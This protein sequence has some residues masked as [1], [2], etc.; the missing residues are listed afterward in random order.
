MVWHIGRSSLEVTYATEFARMY[1]LMI[2]EVFLKEKKFMEMW[3]DIEYEGDKIADG[4]ILKWDG[5]K[6]IASE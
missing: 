5:N 4:Y 1:Y 6:G 2:T 3:I